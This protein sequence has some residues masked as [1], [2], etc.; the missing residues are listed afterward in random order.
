MANKDKQEKAA[1]KKKREVR[2]ARREG[3]REVRNLL[4]KEVDGEE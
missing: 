4:L 3:A 1:N 2:D